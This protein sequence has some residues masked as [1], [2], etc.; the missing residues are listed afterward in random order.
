M[1]NEPAPDEPISICG[2]GEPVAANISGLKA[3]IVAVPILATQSLPAASKASAKG[4]ESEPSDVLMMTSGCGD[5]DVSSCAGEYLKTASFGELAT[6]SEPLASKARAVGPVRPLMVTAG[7]CAPP[8]ASCSGSKR[9]TVPVSKFATHNLCNPSNAI[10]DG[11]RSDCSVGAM[12]VLATLSPEAARTSGENAR[13]RESSALATHMVPASSNA[14]PLMVSRD[15][16]DVV[17][18]VLAICRP[19][20]SSWSGA[21]RRMAGSIPLAIQRPSLASAT[22]GVR[23]SGAFESYPHP[24]AIAISTAIAE[25]RRAISIMF[26]SRK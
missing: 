21:R 4:L 16:L 10:P 23:Y 20:D 19:L 8:K 5:P 14:M 18:V 13:T 1:T 3:A 2:A 6:H 9:T 12:T 11:A 17:T 15:A 22:G 25:R 7:V 24:L 26:G